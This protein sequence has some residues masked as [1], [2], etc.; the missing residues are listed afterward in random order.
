[1]VPEFEQAMNELAIGG[2]SEPVQS[3]FGLHLIQAQE[4]RTVEIEPKQL[5]EQ[6]K[7]A[8]RESKYEE[9]YR[10][11]IKELRARAYVEVREWLD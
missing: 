3:R 1:M 5:R 11:W 7:A 10:E 6:A 9:A 2:L 4:R 8:L